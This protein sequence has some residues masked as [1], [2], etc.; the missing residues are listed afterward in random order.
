MI[1]DLLASQ[2]EG[3]SLERPFY[4]DADIYALENDRLFPRQWSVV[5]HVADLPQRG[6][7][8]VRSLFGQEIIVVNAG[9]HG[10]RAF[11]NVCTHRGSRICKGDGKSPMLVCPY[12]AWSFQ[13]TGELRTTRDLPASVDPTH[14]GLHPVACREI[15]GLI[16][17]GLDVA[18]MPSLDA[19]EQALLPT[20]RQHGIERARV[21]VRRSYPT[22]ANWKLVLENFYECYHCRPSHP[23]YFRMNGHIAATAISDPV[24]AG[25]WEETVATWRA[26][27][28]DAPYNREIRVAGD[29]DEARFTTYRHPIGLGR[30]TASRT[31]DPVAPL[32]GGFTDYDGGETALHLGMFGFLGAYNDHAVLFQFVPVGPEETNVVLTWLV[33]AEADLAAIDEDALTFLWDVTTRQDKGIVEE[34]AR[35]V[36]SPA[37]RPGPYT[38][39]EA[40]TAGF[41]SHYGAMM[42]TLLSG[43]SG[44]Q[45]PL[46]VDA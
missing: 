39:L 35:G 30:R 37:Y 17:C 4:R 36:D 23:E 19:M 21:A 31:G 6:A 22:R 46:R 13:L 42:R 41:V 25:A 33:D 14:L 45:D 16:L 34:N 1:A 24:A 7:H 2:R 27:L 9:G 44:T 28:A 38:V 5:A 10:F 15:G 11:H 43:D 12:H 20:L 32:M 18:A 40:Q 29:V 8:V 26:G 3:W